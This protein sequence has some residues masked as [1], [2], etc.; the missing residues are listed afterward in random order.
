[1]VSVRGSPIRL[2]TFHA[3]QADLVPSIFAPRPLAANVLGTWQGNLA[4]GIE[5]FLY[6][7]HAVRPQGVRGLLNFLPV[8]EPTTDV[9]HVEPRAA[10]DPGAAL[11]SSVPI[12]HEVVD[13]P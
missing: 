12:V 4:E 10:R 11:E 6:D 5:H 8:V 13:R 1:M 7:L 3:I 2:S 9:V